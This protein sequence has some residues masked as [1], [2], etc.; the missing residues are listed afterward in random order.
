[1]KVHY[2]HEFTSVVEPIWD[3]TNTYLYYL[4]ILTRWLVPL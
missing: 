3:M 4:A 2:F 1:M